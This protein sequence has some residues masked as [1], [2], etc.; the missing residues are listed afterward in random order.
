MTGVVCLSGRLAYSIF[1]FCVIGRARCAVWHGAEV[2]SPGG[3][4]VIAG[5]FPYFS[6]KHLE[7]AEAFL[8][9]VD[10]INN[11]TSILPNVTI[12]ADWKNAL[13]SGVIGASA[14]VDQYL[15]Y[16]EK[17]V[18]I[19]GPACSSASMSVATV[20][21]TLYS[22]PQISHA[23]T[24]PSLSDTVEYPYFSRAIASDSFAAKVMA[25]V[26][27]AYGW[28][29]IAVLYSSDEYGSNLA[30]A[31]Q[32]NAAERVIA[33]YGF[34]KY[35]GFGDGVDESAE[36]L[37]NQMA[38]ATEMIDNVVHLNSI[39]IVAIM[40]NRNTDIETIL[41]AAAA[42]SIARGVDPAEYIFILGEVAVDVP[43]ELNTTIPGHLIHVSPAVG[44][45]Y[46]EFVD[47]L[48]RLNET[49][50]VCELTPNRYDENGDVSIYFYAPFAYD[51][52]WAVAFALDNMTKAGFDPFDGDALQLALRSVVFEGVTGE[53]ALDLNGERKSPFDI[54]HSYNT[55]YWTEAFTWSA[56]SGL[57]VINNETTSALATVTHA[58]APDAPNAPIGSSMDDVLEFT[59][60][61]P[62]LFG[63]PITSYQVRV[64]KDAD[65]DTDTI[66]STNRTLLH[67]HHVIF[68]VTYCVS[69]VAVSIGG[70]GAESDAGCVTAMAACSVGSYALDY[71]TCATCPVGHFADQAR[72]APTSC[73]AC[74]LGK[75]A[76]QPGMGQCL[77][78]ESTEVAPSLASE[79]CK[80][81][82]RGAKCPKSKNII[83]LAGY[84][85]TGS[86]DSEVHECPLKQY[87]C[88]GGNFSASFRCNVGF[89][90]ALCATC[91]QGY[92]ESMRG[93]GGV[94]TCRQC[95]NK[96]TA[97][98]TVLLILLIVVLV[99]AV[100]TH[101][102]VL[103]TGIVQQAQLSNMRRK[104]I[105]L[106]LDAPMCKVVFSAYQIISSVTW[107][108]VRDG[109]G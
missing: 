106:S 103:H 72:E 32:E 77:D 27:K 2:L 88:P 19:L 37:E 98:F 11:D 14:A 78:C 6:A 75:Y 104:C 65:A 60:F 39:K 35:F 101:F 56:T 55:A 84:W 86:P 59:W 26:A 67:I 100:A 93:T 90:G 80:R 61:A 15:T 85:T 54:S 28:G 44:S 34:E 91:E 83:V 7:S 8:M 4:L 51:A 22:M 43:A 3:E 30:A 63:V 96:S 62:E 68:G 87:G 53:F 46:T 36:E 33:T 92:Y 107:C 47:K 105:S 95:G 81:C 94:G 9:A 79:Q 76:P 52:A 31:F 48:I 50:P 38:A 82:P 64:R 66:T 23:S 102:K 42:S 74:P 40:A 58:F 5:L 109:G 12:T 69:V 29:R 10:E 108:V 1:F 70:E 13:C 20:T 21:S 25:D 57:V 24:S 18:A 41:S 45:R 16:G 49:C 89:K 99:L 17:I 73:T 97:L 71:A